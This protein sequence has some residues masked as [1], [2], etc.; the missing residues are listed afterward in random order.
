MA[1]FLYWLLPAGLLRSVTATS[2]FLDSGLD[3][4]ISALRGCASAGVAAAADCGKVFK[5]DDMCV[6]RKVN[7]FPIPFSVRVRVNR[8]SRPNYEL[9][10]NEQP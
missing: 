4:P 9:R 1:K 3:D 10:V 2:F 7:F 5:A 6:A 8:R